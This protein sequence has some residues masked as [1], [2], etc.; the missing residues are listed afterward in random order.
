MIAEFAVPSLVGS[1]AKRLR[2]D[3]D[4]RAPSSSELT[5]IAGH[6]SV[7]AREGRIVVTALLARGLFQV[8]EP[9]GKTSIEF[10]CKRRDELN[11]RKI[12][13]VMTDLK[14]YHRLLH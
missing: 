9:V 14:R 8:C 11:R 6:Q 13:G 3:C 1:I 2:N 5:G 7:V 4:A 10:L 12:H